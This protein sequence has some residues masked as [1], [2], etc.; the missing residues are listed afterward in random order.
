MRPLRPAM[1]PDTHDHNGDTA[2]HVFDTGNSQR[3][4]LTPGWVRIDRD[5]VEAASVEDLQKIAQL[6]RPDLENVTLLCR[7]TEPRPVLPRGGQCVA[8]G[9]A[10]TRVLYAACP[11]CWTNDNF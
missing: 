10:G 8:E 4:A 5:W 11:Q 6:S 3:R 9:G 1:D 7:A 2:F